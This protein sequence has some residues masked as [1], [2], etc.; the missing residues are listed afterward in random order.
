MVRPSAKRRSLHV[1]RPG[2]RP[3]E[4][5]YALLGRRTRETLPCHRPEERPCAPRQQRRRL[6]AAILTRLS[7]ICD[8]LH[9]RRRRLK[10]RAFTNDCAALNNRLPTLRSQ[11][12]MV[13]W[14]P[15]LWQLDEEVRLNLCRVLAGVAEGRRHFVGI[16]QNG[17]PCDAASFS[18]R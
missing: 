9:T 2:H 17:W 15:Q 14:S 5:Q 7:L 13:P 12:Q 16:P 10:S 6:A 8:A 18:L 4:R 11:M 1:A 3:E